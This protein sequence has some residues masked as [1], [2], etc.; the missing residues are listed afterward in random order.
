MVDQTHVVTYEIAQR[1]NGR[2]AILPAGG[3]AIPEDA[4]EYLTREEAEDALFSL[5]ET[6]DET[7]RDMPII[8]PGGGQSVF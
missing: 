3:L 6:L 8:K 7:E 1:P 2:F 5:D 4:E